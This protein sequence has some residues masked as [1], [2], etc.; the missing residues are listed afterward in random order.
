VTYTLAPDLARRTGAVTTAYNV[1]DEKIIRTAG[2]SPQRIDHRHMR[3]AARDDNVKR[4]HCEDAAFEP[5]NNTALHHLLLSVEFVGR[6]KVLSRVI[7]ADSH[8]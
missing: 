2:H 4:R 1:L 6:Q 3:H 5:T 8:D 7:R